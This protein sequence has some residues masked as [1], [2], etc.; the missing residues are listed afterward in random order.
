M[1]TQCC[2]NSEDVWDE[3]KRTERHK[4]RPVSL[5]SKREKNLS[6]QVHKLQEENCDLKDK[7]HYM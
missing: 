6:K 4:I 7:V 5:K 2:L 1:A 3:M